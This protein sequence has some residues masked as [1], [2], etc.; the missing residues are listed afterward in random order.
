MQ[1]AAGTAPALPP[2]PLRRSVW[3]T[4]GLVWECSAVEILRFMADGEAVDAP[5]PKD[6]DEGDLLRMFRWMVLLRTF[7]ERAVAL[8]RQGRLGTYP[9]FWGEEA[10]QAGP[11]CACRDDDWV[12]PSYRQGAIGILRGL[13]PSTIFKYRRGFGGRHGFWNTR[14]LRVGPS[15]VSIGTHL[16]HAVGVGYAAKIKGDSVVSLVWSGDGAASEG[17][18]HE[19]LNLAAVWKVPTVFF[20]VN[21]Q[22]AISTPFARQSATATLAERAPAYGLHAERVD[23]FDVVACWKATRDA[24]ERARS[25]GGPT[26][27]EAW[28]YRLAPHGTADDPSKY[29]DEAETERWRRLEPLGRTASYLRGLGLL[30]DGSEKQIYD[31]ARA[32]I[33]AEVRETEK[34]T[35]TDSDILFETLYS[36]PAREAKG[37]DEPYGYHS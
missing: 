32:A 6:L 13:P 17:D 12:F 30:D 22:W 37:A 3:A 26:L 29:R 21:N 14:T 1:P 2:C 7:D 4:G 24:L 28:C 25:G 16:S 11:L 27:I 20:C 31:E 34:L 8:Q 18:W 10:T 33:S 23:G 5:P 9:T 15:V 35:E 36:S 19:A